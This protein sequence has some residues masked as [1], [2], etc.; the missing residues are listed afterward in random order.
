MNISSMV[1]NE[2]PPWVDQFDSPY[3]AINDAFMAEMEALL[4]MNDAYIED[5]LKQDGPKAGAN[6]K[7]ILRGP[8]S[9]NTLQLLGQVT[10]CLR[11]AGQRDKVDEVRDRVMG[12]H[13]PELAL[14]AMMDYVD[15]RP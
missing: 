10:R 14:D 6:R 11:Q 13:S 2:D 1:P 8:L 12:S 4:Q 7:P 5:L 9:R 15:M 3:Y